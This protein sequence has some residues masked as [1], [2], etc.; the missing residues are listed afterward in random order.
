MDKEIERLQNL[1]THEIDSL[2]YAV[3][4]IEKLGIRLT[5][6]EHQVNDLMHWKNP[7]SFQPRFEFMETTVA[8]FIP[9][10]QTIERKFEKLTSE[11]LVEIVSDEEL[12]DL[13]K[14]SGVPLKNIAEHF[15][16]SIPAVSQWVNGD[17][18][19]ILVRS[20]L[21]RFLIENAVL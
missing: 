11:K 15:H 6:L 7:E 10:L 17:I 5:N 13:Y 1:F 3:S 8:D 9:R 20:N 2:R 12:H 21:K 4:N 14:N 18:K 16:V 19:D